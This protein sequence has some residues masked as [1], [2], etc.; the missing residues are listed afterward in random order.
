M[1][2]IFDTNFW[3]Y[4]AD[5]SLESSFLEL[6]KKLKLDIILPPSILLE[7]QKTKD[8]VKR[9]KIIK[10]MNKKWRKKSRTEADLESEEVVFEIKR[11]CPKYK[12]KYINTNNVKRLRKFWLKHIWESAI[13]KT[14]FYHNSMIYSNITEIQIAIREQEENKKYFKDAK[15]DLNKTIP[16]SFQAEI[17]DKDLIAYKHSKVGKKYEPWRVVNLHYY[18]KQLLNYSLPIGHNGRTV[19]DWCEAWINIPEFLKDEAAF[20]QFWLEQV[21]TKNMPRN[22]LRCAVRLLQPF[23]KISEGNPYDEQHSAYLVNTEIFYT[24]DRRYY[25]TLQTIHN[26]DVIKFAKPILLGADMLESL[27]TIEKSI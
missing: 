3:S 6:E 25:Q 12:R 14:D 20:C 2:V 11:N 7:T 22:W 16:S 10:A 18:R 4:L 23:R 26:D 17:S 8:E 19:V 15:W 24:C 5:S 1:R 13:A 21:E 9:L 27:T